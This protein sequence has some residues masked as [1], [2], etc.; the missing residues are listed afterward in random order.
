[1]NSKPPW[2]AFILM[3]WAIFFLMGMFGGYLIFSEP[4]PATQS[5]PPDDLSASLSLNL[6][7][8]D[9]LARDGRVWV[10][11][12]LGQEVFYCETFIRHSGQSNFINIS[13]DDASDI[14]DSSFTITIRTDTHQDP[15][16]TYT[17]ALSWKCLIGRHDTLVI[18]LA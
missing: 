2:V 14:N 11:D 10:R 9:T 13:W 12:D 3:T 7:N 8:Y 17:T 15:P 4:P 18:T 1:M 5:E 16:I 6:L